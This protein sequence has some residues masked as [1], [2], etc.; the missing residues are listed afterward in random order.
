MKKIVSILVLFFCISLTAQEKPKTQIVEAACGQCQFGMKSKGGCDLAVR[1][2][3]KSYFVDGTDINKHGDAH[4]TDG[5]CS[6]IRKA[7]VVGEVKNDRFVVSS[8]KL[9]PAKE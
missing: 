2:D 9:L 8:F 3:G 5:F 7:E 4:A 6:A 1:I